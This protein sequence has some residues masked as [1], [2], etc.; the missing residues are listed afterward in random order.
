MEQEERK[1]ESRKTCLKKQTVFVLGLN[2]LILEFQ[3]KARKY[4]LLKENKNLSE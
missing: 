4:A 1:L 2:I 3:D